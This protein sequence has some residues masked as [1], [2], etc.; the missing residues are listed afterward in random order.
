LTPNP[1]TETV[2]LRIE[3][4]I[5]TDIPIDDLTT[6]LE[7]DGLSTFETDDHSENPPTDIVAFNELRSCA[8]LFRLKKRGLLD[9]SPTFQRDFVWPPMAQTRFIDSLMKGLPIPSMCFAHDWKRDHY[10]VIDGLQRISTIVKFLNEDEQWR[11][12]NEE[13]IEPKI[14]GKTVSEIRE[15]SPSLRK[16]YDRV[17]NMSIPVTILRCDMSKTS[18]SEYVFTIFHRLNT[19][20]SKLNNQ[21]IRN[22]IFNGSFNNLLAKLDSNPNWRKLNRMKPAQNYRY[23]KQELILRLFAF[24]DNFKG[25][26]GRLSKFL[27]EYMRKHRYE[28][29][30][31]LIRKE[32]L[33]NETVD[34]ALTKIWNGDAPDKINVSVFEATLVG[35]AANI[36]LLREAS[37]AEC[38]A[39]F[40]QLINSNAFT[41]EKLKEGLSGKPRVIERM[42]T[43]ID[44]FGPNGH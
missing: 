12:S 32:R 30:E 33:F 40:Q 18:H 31:F 26:G 36:Q 4:R 37:G 39:R 21:E 34:V 7:E 27:N 9:L 8:D 29:E 42:T 17:E 13:D 6:N 15:G 3:E 10:Q 41:P 23:T 28:K 22:C 24:H 1:A 2:Q 25:Y 11:L 20:G 43:A 19:G 38:R 14:A 44:I 5:L 16:Y 35:V